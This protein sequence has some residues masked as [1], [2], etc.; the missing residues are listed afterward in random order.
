[1]LNVDGGGIC[2]LRRK[3]E[4]IAGIQLVAVRGQ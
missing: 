2:L 1:M 4:S 3:L